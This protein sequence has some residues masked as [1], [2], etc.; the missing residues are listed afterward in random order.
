MWGRKRSG[1]GMLATWP[2]LALAGLLLASGIVAMERSARQVGEQSRQLDA[3]RQARL[4]LGELR[5]A[6]DDCAERLAANEE[7][8][9]A[10]SARVDS[11]RALVAS[12]ESDQ[13]TVPA[14]QFDNY[15]AVFDEYNAS[16]P[17][18]HELADALQ[19]ES[20]ACRE[21]ATRHNALAD[22]LNSLAEPLP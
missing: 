4:D 19:V 11:L 22:S 16:V 6:A 3:L 9:H 20:S 17:T 12:Y 1:P 18:W 13:R 15:M 2:W 8:F 21:L 5:V 7:S 14:E 10:Y